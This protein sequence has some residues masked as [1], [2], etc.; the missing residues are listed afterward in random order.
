MVRG[1]SAYPSIYGVCQRSECRRTLDIPASSYELCS[2]PV[3]RVATSSQD[4]MGTTYVAIAPTPEA[5]RCIA[6]ACQRATRIASEKLCWGGHTARSGLFTL[7]TDP[8][9]PKTSVSPNFYDTELTA[10]NDGYR[11][12]RKYQTRCY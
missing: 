2:C 3:A 4:R 11:C 5:Y 7:P 1:A 10:C 8:G 12:L 9:T 6:F